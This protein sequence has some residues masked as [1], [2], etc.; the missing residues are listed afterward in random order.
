MATLRFTQFRA[1][2]ISPRLNRMRLNDYSTNR[3]FGSNSNG[4]V[5]QGKP[6]DEI[7][8]PISPV[9][10]PTDEVL[11][12]DPEYPDMKSYLPR[13]R[14]R[15]K[16][17]RY[18]IGMNYGQ[19]GKW[20]LS[21]GLEC[22]PAPEL[23]AAVQGA[24]MLPHEIEASLHYYA[25][26]SYT[27][28]KEKEIIFNESADDEKG[29][30]TISAGLDFEDRNAVLYALQTPAA[31][32]RLVIRCMINVA[33]K[34]EARGLTAGSEVNTAQILLDKN[35][36]QPGEA[37]VITLPE[38]A[39]AN[40]DIYIYKQGTPYNDRN[41]IWGTAVWIMNSNP[42]SI[43]APAEPGTYVVRLHSTGPVSDT[44]LKATNTFTV[45]EISP[46]QPQEPETPLY[47]TVLLLL[48]NTAVAEPFLLLPRDA[49][50]YFYNDT[51]TGGYSGA[52]EFYRISLSYPK[53]PSNPQHAYF[54]SKSKPWEFY[55]LPDKFKLAR[56]G[57]APFLPRM[58]ISI[59]SHDG[60]V[61]NA[62]VTVEFTVKPWIVSAR[63]KAAEDDL[64]RWIPA[65]ARITEPM[66][67][68]LHAK[69]SLNLR[70][71]NGLDPSGQ[72][73]L[74]DLAN[75]FIHSLTMSLDDFHKFFAAAC[76]CNAYSIGNVVVDTGLPV[77]EFV[78]VEI[79]FADTHG[80]ILTFKQASY[81]DA[82]GIISFRMRN[83]IE[84]D[85][86]LRSLPVWLRQ[87]DRLVKASVEDIGFPIEL[88][89]GDEVQFKIRLPEQLANDGT[90]E[91]D[92]DTAKAEIVPIQANIL[93][94]ICDTT[95]QYNSMRKINVKIAP[96]VL[97]DMDDTNP[98]TNIF[99][100]FLHSDS[101]TLSRDQPQGIANVRVS[102]MDLLRGRD[103]QGKYAFRQQI[104]RLYKYEPVGQYRE[105]DWGYLELPVKE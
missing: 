75:G 93:E 6:R 16:G 66:L 63:L 56:R 90:M 43:E 79:C 86:R 71:P 41:Y 58:A 20:R 50:S 49:H 36:Y 4:D 62:R 65:G 51:D 89:P 64:K 39:S 9:S 97:S 25:W 8:T 82:D 91:I 60:S 40:D 95:E 2:N 28:E 47:R 48:D 29:G 11:F 59:A 74:I 70:I 87:G 21:I 104:I 102:F 92:F 99:V 15:N 84:S 17:S 94:S 24:A 18:E 19:D 12:E 72:D 100:E 14:M 37:M 33:V 44:T 32:P 96:K 68:P 5:S 78:P 80:K 55:Y 69:A 67:S 101:L 83:D 61:E 42:F 81:A 46:P 38:V 1:G 10:D 85:I 76:S 30:K 105:C 98:I 103:S 23:C 57:I 7:H 3:P 45:G 34:I 77:P 13:Y 22:F 27:I 88:V 73:D 35:A 31:N 54:Q 52:A 26:P 53:G